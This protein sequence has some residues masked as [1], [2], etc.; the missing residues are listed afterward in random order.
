MPFSRLLF[1]VTP[2]WQVVDEYD[3][4]PYR[5]NKWTQFKL[6]LILLTVE[7]QRKP[8]STMTMAGV[9][10]VPKTSPARQALIAAI[11]RF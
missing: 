7:W 8:N 1:S 5:K 4:G 9:R 2:H 6:S 3:A 10:M 11:T